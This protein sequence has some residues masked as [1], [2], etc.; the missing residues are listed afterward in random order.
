MGRREEW[1]LGVSTWRK[2]SDVGVDRGEALM[3]K[4]TFYETHW[5]CHSDFS[6]RRC[7]A[8]YRIFLSITWDNELA[9]FNH[10]DFINNAWIHYF[11]RYMIRNLLYNLGL[12]FSM[13]SQEEYVL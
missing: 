6:S 13:I 12:E 3:L 7:T 5:I 11:T 9:L 2:E 1:R 10:I 8:L 4:G